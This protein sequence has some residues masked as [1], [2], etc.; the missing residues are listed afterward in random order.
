MQ[1]LQGQSGL[2]IV[3]DSSD[4]EGDHPAYL[5]ARK[6]FRA[7]QAAQRQKRLAMRSENQTRLVASRGKSSGTKGRIVLLAASGGS[8][9][10]FFTARAVRRAAK[11][12]KFLALWERGR[13][14]GIN[15]PQLYNPHPG[16]LPKGE[17][18]FSLVPT[19]YVGMPVPTL[20][21]VP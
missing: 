1:A 13:A 4:F 21:V 5:A 10:P 16:F 19:L 6:A 12:S 18:L 20:R 8:V 7:E 17:P 3:A 15:G 9:S 11:M 2:G 14:E